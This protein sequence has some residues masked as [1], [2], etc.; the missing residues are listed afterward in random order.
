MYFIKTV[1]LTLSIALLSF[2]H[3]LAQHERDPAQF[4]KITL[5][6]EDFKKICTL[7]STGENVHYRLSHQEFNSLK[8][9]ASKGA[10][11]QVDYIARPSWPDEAVEAFEYA[12]EIWETYLD[13]D[14]PIRVQAN[15]TQLGEFTLGSAGP[16]Q[17]VQLEG[18]EEPTWYS[19]AQ[20]SAISGIDFVAQSQGTSSEVNHDVI[21]NMNAGWDNWYFGTDAQTPGGLIDFVTVV[22]HEIGHG[23]GFTGSMQVPTGQTAQWGYGAPPIPII[24]DRFVI[25]SDGSQIIDN[26]VYRSPSGKLYDAVTSRTGGIFFGGINTIGTYNGDAA[27]L[28]APSEWNGGSSY[29]HLD[30]ATFTNTE[31]ALM[32]PQ[33]DRAFAIHSPGPIMCSI[34]GDMGWPLAENCQN[35][36]GTESEIMVNQV[37]DNKIDFGVTN[38]GLDIENTFTISNGPNAIDPLVGRIGISGSSS[39]AVVNSKQIFVLDPGESTNITVRYQPG[40]EGEVTG[41]LEIVHNGTEGENPIIISLGGEALPEDKVFVLDQNYPNPFNATTTIPYALSQT[42]DVRLEVFDPLGKHVQTLV[43]S[44]QPSGRYNQPFQAD[45]VSSGLFIYR[46]IVDG[47]SKT[48]KLLLVK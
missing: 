33:I 10:S 18:D 14:I 44:R 34:F 46:L 9:S 16:S 27:P 19:I 15:W 32:R 23:I 8:K 31:N 43:D 29:S 39:F 5:D 17:I 3:T 24:Y 35:L 38:V 22:L 48:G 11:I 37:L 21:V 30:L 26:Q 41:A 13:S 28:Y 47:K 7:T 4:N 36:L 42:A 2:S 6:N 25:D 20:G 40:A 1:F 45:N 12:V